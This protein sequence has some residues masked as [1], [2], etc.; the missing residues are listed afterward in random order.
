MAS[1]RKIGLLF[2]YDES[3]AG[4]LY[5]L[6]NI[7]A[8]LGRLPDEE[9]PEIVAFYRFRVVIPLIQRTGYPYLRILPLRRGFGFAEKIFKAV[10][11]RL[12]LA[13]QYS[14][15]SVEFVFPCDYNAE[16]LLV[17]FRSIRK[18]YWIPDFQHRH[19]PHF[20][21]AEE[22]ERRNRS[23]SKIA[24]AQVSIVLSSNDSKEDFEA[25]CPDH[26]GR[27]TVLQFAAVLPDFTGVDI[28]QL[29][30][31]FGLSRKYF[32]SPNQFWAHKNHIVILRAL[33]RLRAKGVECQV[34]FTGKQIDYRNPDYFPSLVKYV[35]EEGLNEYVVFLGFIDRNEQLALMQ[36]AIAVIQPSLFEGWSTVI[37]DAKA[38]G[39]IVVASSLAVNREQC[40]D[41][42]LYFDPHD[43]VGLAEH[44]E[45]L[46]HHDLSFKSENYNY[47]ILHFARGILNL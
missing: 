44:L 26:N 43:D 16:P 41:A 17:S 13:R 18:V 3:W 21:S 7:I 8:A 36:H 47:R 35:E 5:Y 45:V 40:G 46:L 39:Q 42:A 37:E 28:G 11:M 22:I 32:I 2:V 20:F 10:G 12:L 25:F 27:V 38:I 1:R 9:R 29:L 31:R 30:T 15:K 34:V 24:R 14:R 33:T 23:I 4:G 6:L 19:L